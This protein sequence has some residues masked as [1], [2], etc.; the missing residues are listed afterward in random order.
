MI[1]S[2]KIK[3]TVLSAFIVL[4][5]SKPLHADPLPEPWQSQRE[6]KNAMLS[7]ACEY[8]I[9]KDLDAVRQLIKSGDPVMMSNTGWIMGNCANH[10]PDM[11]EEIAANYQMRAALAGYPIAISAYGS[12]LIRGDLGVPK[13]VNLGLMMKERAIELGFGLSAIDL[14]NFYTFGKYLPLDLEKAKKYIAIAE[15]ENVDSG[16]IKS[17]REAIRLA[18][19]KPQNSQPKSQPLPATSSSDIFEVVI[20]IGLTG[21]RVPKI[22]NRQNMGQWFDEVIYVAQ[23]FER[24][25]GCWTSGSMFMV[26]ERRVD[27]SEYAAK[28]LSQLLASSDEAKAKGLVGHNVS[29]FRSL[30]EGITFLEEKPGRVDS[31][32]QPPM[33]SLTEAKRYG[34]RCS[35][36][37]DKILYPIPVRMRGY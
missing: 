26:G 27:L 17:Q 6:E 4:L 7:G 28:P 2:G 25:G 34:P 14:A 10:F 11:T 36:N 31:T 21:K 32:G 9:K 5:G 3:L 33:W 29:N 19:A 24:Q 35:H 20:H 30:S 13:D 37:K 15:A 12:R 16:I 1:F 8:G 18:E 23:A 22:G